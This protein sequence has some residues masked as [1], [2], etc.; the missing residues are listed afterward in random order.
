MIWSVLAGAVN[1]IALVTHGILSGP[2]I[3]NINNPNMSKL[4][5]TNT[6]LQH[7]HL[8][9]C[10]RL[11]FVDIAQVLAETIKRGHYGLSGVA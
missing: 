11:V 6:I 2:A 1:I 5:M 9:A 4:V 8:E 3:S 7:E 10:N